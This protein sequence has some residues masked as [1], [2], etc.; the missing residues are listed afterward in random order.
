VTVKRLSASDL[1]R[2]MV[3]ME[4]MYFQDY[5]S[6]LERSPWPVASGTPGQRS[7]G[8]Q[9]NWAGLTAPNSPLLL[10]A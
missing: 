1:G 2:L 9:P 8:R 6:L 3:E 4:Q 5:A 10:F 7:I